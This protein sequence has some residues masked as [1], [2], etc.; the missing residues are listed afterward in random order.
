MGGGTGS[1]LLSGDVYVPKA[2]DG[3]RLAD[4]NSAVYIRA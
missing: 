2:V 4:R 3:R 1:S